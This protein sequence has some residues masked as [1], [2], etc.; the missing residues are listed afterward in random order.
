MRGCGSAGA[1]F[2]VG[3]GAV[4]L[5]GAGLC[6]PASGGVPA[7]EIREI[8]VV[9]PGDFGSQGF[10]VSNN[11]IATGRSLGTLGRA[12]RWV[13]GGGL[14]PLPNLPGRDFCS[15]NGV[16][17]SGIVVG[18]GAQTSFGA[19][20]L[21]VLWTTNTVQQLPLPAGFGVGR[22]NDIN[23]GGIAVG[24]VGGGIQ[25]S[26][27]I[28]GETVELIT[29]TTDQ[30]ASIRTA[31]SVNNAGRVVGFGIDP[32]NAGRNVGFVFDS[33]TGD[34]FE[35]GALIGANGALAFDVSEAG[36]VVGSS[37]LN[38][39]SGRPFIWSDAG[40]IEAIPLPTGTSQGS[41]RGVNSDGWAVGTASSAFAVPFLFDG[42]TTHRI[43]DLIPDGT[44]WDLDMNTSSSAIGINDDGVIVGTGVLNGQVRG[45]ALIP[46]GGGCNDGDLVE[47]FGVL[48]LADVQAFI[49]AFNAGCP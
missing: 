4:I 22:A 40:G 47:P 25:E 23:D 34:A 18:T 8:G 6:A 33:A 45:Y 17:I 37:M 12:F 19:G 32:G 9:D 26:A 13:D 46:V 41:A 29:Q 31:F 15:G 1:V 44:G 2:G 43:A 3:F 35:V 38:Q 27:V 16:N 42:E 5:A 7:Y 36:H 28:W 11:G 49:G 14:E 10:R 21:P 24:S 30:G 20:A 39:S 48:D